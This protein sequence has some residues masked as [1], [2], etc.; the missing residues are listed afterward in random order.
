MRT[1]AGLKSHLTALALLASV[2]W[3][4]AAW[5][6]GTVGG[7]T[8]VV[9]DAAGAP[10]DGAFVQMKNA[11]RRLHFMVISKEQGR[12]ALDRL[13]A[14]KYVVQAVGGEHQSA[15]SAPVEVAAGK[16]SPVNLSLTVARAPAL[17]PAW[18]GRAPG[19]RGAEA[20]AA[21]GGGPRLPRATARPSSR[22]NACPATTQRASSA[23]AAIRRAGNRSCAA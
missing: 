1:S 12:Y 3:P 20:E 8:G 15:P 11:E 6:Q 16:S 17:P 7:L 9:T 14:G 21:L 19:E 2:F 18:P 22:R 13:P 4:D 10:L 23:R 5:T